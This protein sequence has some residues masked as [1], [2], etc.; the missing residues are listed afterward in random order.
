VV[1]D[2]SPGYGFTGILIALMAFN[3]PIAILPVSILFGMLSVGAVGM[4]LQSGVP[5]ELSE[6]VQAL[7][8]L[9]IAAQ[10]GLGK[11]LGRVPFR[12][13]AASEGKFDIGDVGE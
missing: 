13:R 9:F 12:S 11:A 8:I 10:A 7:I 3:D 1:Q 5:N 2:F 4:E 6:V